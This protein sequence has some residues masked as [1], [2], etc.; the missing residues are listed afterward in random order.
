MCDNKKDLVGS[1][2]KL[3]CCCKS[4]AWSRLWFEVLLP[5]PSDLCNDRARSLTDVQRVAQLL[6]TVFG[7]GVATGDAAKDTLGGFQALHEHRILVEARVSE[8]LLVVHPDRDG[9]A[10]LGLQLLVQFLDGRLGRFLVIGDEDIE[11]FVAS[12]FV[13]L[14]MVCFFSI[15]FESKW[16]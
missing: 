12:H 3:P 4:W 11:R 6:L 10:V 14:R 16:L 15:L 7:L 8:P 13:L 5:R 9:L 2:Y 1:Y